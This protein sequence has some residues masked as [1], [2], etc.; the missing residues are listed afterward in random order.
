[1]LLCM[2]LG[3]WTS[4]S[5][6]TRPPPTPLNH[7]GVTFS[8]ARE[9][10]L[11]PYSLT[12]EDLH[13]EGEPRFVTLGMGAKRRI[14]MV[15]WTLHADRIRLIS[16]WKAD[17]PQRQHYER[18]FRSR[19]RS[20]RRSG[21]RRCETGVRYPC[22][23]GTPSR[24][25]WKIADHNSRRQR[26]VSVFRTRAEMTGGNYQTLMNETLRQVALG[27]TLAEVVRETIRAELR[28]D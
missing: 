26:Y 19:L 18:Q 1:M 11:D 4:N 9:V 16:S 23:S 21:L 25:G 8:E 5:T 14:L 10:L 17:Q 28:G 6:P 24:A 2:H 12:R 13:A 15:V 22:L 3:L 20:L 27:Y 7:D